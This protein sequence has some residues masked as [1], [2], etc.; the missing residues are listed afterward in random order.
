MS[1]NALLVELELMPLWQLRE[2]CR[3]PASIATDAWTAVEISTAQGADGWALLPRPLSGDEETLFTN[4][5]FAMQLQRGADIEVDR[6]G[7]LDA[8]ERN[9]ISWLWLAGAEAANKLDI[10]PLTA[11]SKA[12]WKD[13]PVFFSAHPADLLAQPELKGR[14]WAD[15]CR[16]NA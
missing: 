10:V 12:I 1:N 4:L 14:L 6:A 15:W 16:Y 3:E 13:L 2:S 5:L 9:T 11:V 7:L 8:A